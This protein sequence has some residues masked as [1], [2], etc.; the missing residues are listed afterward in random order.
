MALS[1]TPGDESIRL[2]AEDRWVNQEQFYTVEG[3]L[4]TEE[5]ALLKKR[6][7][8]EIGD[9]EDQPKNFE[10]AEITIE[11]YHKGK[12]KTFHSQLNTALVSLCRK[13]LDDICSRP[14]FHLQV[15]GEPESKGGARNG[16]LIL[17]LVFVPYTLF[18]FGL[19]WL[20]ACV[21]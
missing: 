8:V 5:Y 14:S 20:E 21:S 1:F 15:I 13:I 12:H 19:E 16:W 4:G 2:F 6:L 17:L 18:V 7:G 11:I 10:A 9:L 3:S